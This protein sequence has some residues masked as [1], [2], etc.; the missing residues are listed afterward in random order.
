MSP[1]GYAD[2]TA[3]QAALAG[4]SVTE[5]PAAAAPDAAVLQSAKDTG[6]L[7]TNDLAL[8]GGLAIWAS[9]GRTAIL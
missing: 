6:V 8:A 5:A 7:V 2:A 3:V 9:R 1:A 4:R